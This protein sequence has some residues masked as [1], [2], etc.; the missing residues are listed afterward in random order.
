MFVKEVSFA[1]Q[2]FL[3]LLLLFFT[4]NT[5]KAVILCQYFTIEKTVFCCEVFYNAVYS[6]DGKP[7]F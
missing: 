3:L 4:K 5:V 2:G 1:H 7:C 6:C